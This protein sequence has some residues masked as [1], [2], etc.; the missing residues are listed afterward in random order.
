MHLLSVKIIFRNTSN[1]QGQ[2]NVPCTVKNDV[3]AESLHAIVECD[4]NYHHIYKK[5]KLRPLNGC[6]YLN[7]ER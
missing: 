4:T 1:F 5:K 3:F 6:I 7:C 2:A